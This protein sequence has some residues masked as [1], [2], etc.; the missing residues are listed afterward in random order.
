MWLLHLQ[1]IPWGRERGRVDFDIRSI[2]P[3]GRGGRFLQKLDSGTEIIGVYFFHIQQYYF[4][5]GN[6]TFELGIWIP[7]L[8]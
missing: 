2:P 3:Q 5:L 7:E 4:V 1:G 8:H 6:A